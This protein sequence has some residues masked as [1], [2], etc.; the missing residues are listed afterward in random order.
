MVNP[1]AKTVKIPV[2]GEMKLNMATRRPNMPSESFS[3]CW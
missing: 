3:S 2:D 1:S